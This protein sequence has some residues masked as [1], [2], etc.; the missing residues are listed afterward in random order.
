MDNPD[1]GNKIN[2]ITIGI[3][4]DSKRH[5]VATYEGHKLTRLDMFEAPELIEHIKRMN[6]NE[7]VC[8]IENVCANNFIYGRNNTSIPKVNQEIARSIGRNQQA[9]LEL[10][11]WLEYETIPYILHNPQAGNWANDEQQFR[12]VTKW[13]GKRSNKDTRS[14]AFF[15]FLTL[16]R[17]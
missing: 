7:L 17:A 13:Q 10:L 12:L 11:K 14:A 16:P 5:G 6:T 9:Q 2:M 1:K 15:G 8:G 3:D 4:P